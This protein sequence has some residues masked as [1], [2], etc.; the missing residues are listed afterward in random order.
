MIALARTLGE[1][2]ADGRPALG[3]LRGLGATRAGQIAWFVAFATFARAFTFGDLN[4]HSDELLFFYTGQQMHLG[5]LPYVDIWDRKPPSTFLIYY[6][7]AGISHSVL[8][9][10]IVT[11]LFAALTAFTIALIAERFADRRGAMLAG[12]LYLVTMI[13][14]GGGGGQPAVFFNLLIATAVLLVL[15]YGDVGSGRGTG[16]LLAAMTCAGIAITFK[17]TAVFEGVWLGCYSLWLHSRRSGW[18]AASRIA[19]LLILAGA[20]PMLTAAAFFAL[21]GHFPEFLHA[22]VTSNL[23]KK[24]NPAGDL[25]FRASIILTMLTPLLVA[26]GAGLADRR[27]E[28]VPR[29]FLA[30]WLGAAIVGVTVI[31]GLINHYV[32]PLL[33]PLA[34]TAAPFFNRRPLGPPAGVLLVIIGLLSVPSLDFGKGARSR[35]AVLDLVAEIRRHDSDPRLLVYDGPV[36]LYALIDRRPP[37]PLIFPLHLSYR[38]EN[39]TS[40]LDTAAEFRKVLAWRPTTI[41]SQYRPGADLYNHRTRDP[42]MAY[43]TQRCRQAFVRYLPDDDGGM[44]LQVYT[45]CDASRPLSDRGDR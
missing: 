8:A 9:Y 16:T 35:D 5:A 14:F 31:P 21:R 2:R 23:S 39:N 20:L 15:R 4:F 43:I 36:Y 38:P 29:L 3:W 42:L 1:R 41:V 28:R 34:V 44:V 18:N 19:P 40:H 25:L 33:A 10:Q 27:D 45:G 13:A 24:Y 32:L 30:G 11:L 17:Q 7:I 37:T 6:L 26:A 22:M 12:T